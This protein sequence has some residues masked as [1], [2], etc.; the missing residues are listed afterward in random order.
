MVRRRGEDGRESEKR[1]NGRK[2]RSTSFSP[3]APYTGSTEKC[4]QKEK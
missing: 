3:T 1:E 4:S 2:K